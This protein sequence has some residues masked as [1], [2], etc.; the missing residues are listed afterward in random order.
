MPLSFKDFTQLMRGMPADVPQEQLNAAAQQ[1]EAGTPLQHLWKAANRPLVGGA[2]SPFLQH[3]H[4]E[5]EGTFRRVAEDLGA[6]LTSPLSLGTMALSGGASLAG[7]AGMLGISKGARVAEAALQA[8]FVAE[9]VHNMVAGDS[10]GEK[11]GGA[12]EA[13]LGALGV[14]SAAKHAF[15]VEKV[16]QTYAKEAGLPKLVKPQPDINPQR[17]MRVADNFESM[18]HAPNDPAVK[19]AY[20]A[21]G[22]EIEK[23][24]DFLVNRAGVKI[25]PWTS[26]GQPYASSKHM[27]EDVQKN[28]HLWFFP[29]EGGFGQMSAQDLENPL[30]QKGQ[31]GVVQNDMLRAV[32]DYFGHAQHGFEFGVKGEE[33][34]FQEHAQMMIDPQSRRALATE[35]R[36]QNSWVN[37]NRSLRNEQG[38]LIKKGEPGFVPPSERPYAEQK[39]G[40][41]AEPL[42]EA[43]VPD[44]LDPREFTDPQ[45]SMLTNGEP[46]AIMSAG[47]PDGLTLSPEQNQ[48]RHQQLLKELQAYPVIEQ[49]GHYGKPTPEPSVLVP[50]MQ[51]DAAAALGQK[52]GQ[53][54]VIT[55]QGWNRLAD[56]ANFPRQGVQFGEGAGSYYSE[57]PLQQ[58]QPPVRYAQQFPEQAFEPAPSAAPHAPTPALEAPPA[59]REALAQTATASP[60]E[61][62]YRKLEDPTYQ[63]EVR[64]PEQIKQVAGQSGRDLADGVKRVSGMNAMAVVGPGAAAGIDDSDPN[65]PN[66]NL[67]HYAKL[68]LNVA[69]AVG[70]GSSAAAAAGWFPKGL[71][72]QLEGLQTKLRK[73]QFDEHVAAGGTRANFMLKDAPIE[74]AIR[75]VIKSKATSYNHEQ[76]LLGGWEV[77]ALPEHNGINYDERRTFTQVLAKDA[78]G[79]S[80]T[81]TNPKDAGVKLSDWSKARVMNAYQAGSKRAEQEHWGDA[82]WLYHL[83][84]GEP[85]KATQ[86][87]RL[88]GT[89]SPGSPTDD[90]TLQAIEAFVRSVSGESPEQ[91]IKSLHVGHPRPG[92]LPDNFNR[93]L[94]LG[95]IFNAKT[96]ALAGAEVG[97]H[98]AIPIDMWLLRGLGANTEKTPA[99]GTYRLISEAMAKSAKEAGEDPFP[100]M[101]KVWMGMQDI[102]K[103][104][105]PSFAEAT[106]NL[107]L[108]GHIGDVAG[109]KDVVAGL[110]DHAK[111]PT[112]A[113]RAAKAGDLHAGAR[114]PIAVNPKMGYEEWLQQTQAVMQKGY[115]EGDV[116]G[117]KP[118]PQSK[119]DITLNTLKQ[120]EESARAKW[121]PSRAPAP[122]RQT[123]K[124]AVA[125]AA[126]ESP[127]QAAVKRSK[128]VK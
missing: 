45:R 91:I 62:V 128:P 87:T 74:T 103:T 46:Y 111:Q 53:D 70:L 94:Q 67:K 127:L 13:G 71:K 15:P 80:T 42:T 18:P 16:A 61:S 55:H 96:E 82:R 119:R 8:P 107:K 73:T 34:A 48:L 123:A 95:R 81:S 29:S 100:F 50:G 86:I 57:V 33:G 56:G 35:T 19:S 106:A 12:L 58:G 77:M 17:T 88:L 76:K 60:S 122:V 90:N 52:F 99:D 104:P 31:N 49:Q 125:A 7:K 5:S 22:G 21:L 2:D 59:P 40:L 51:P 44:R 89:F 79:T 110:A 10:T 78:R 69:G 105:T 124:L 27:V 121:T 84:N 72:A 47:D 30:L 109:A 9:G 41:L 108:P 113:R 54:A 98:E 65:D 28:N 117:K 75:K 43:Q 37:G 39:T 1:A 101:A 116:L 112:L 66:Q 120:Q 85:E 26:E 36:G 93:A 97:L 11:L 114:S 126:K 20:G 102:T 38:Q 83:S 118:N 32:H 25:E 115:R 4:A 3:E 6:S 24:Y 63:P 68:G 64:T 23:Q 92:V 14:R